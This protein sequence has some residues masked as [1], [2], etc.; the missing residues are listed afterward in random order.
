MKRLIAAGY[1]VVWETLPEPHIAL[2]CPTEKI[3]LVDRRA[4]PTAIR[5]ALRQCA[6]TVAATAPPQ[7]PE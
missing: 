7:P 4:N 2:L 3:V 5:R 1:R 6:A